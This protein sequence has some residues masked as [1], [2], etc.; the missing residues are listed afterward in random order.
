LAAL[1]AAVAWALAALLIAAPKTGAWTRTGPLSAPGAHL[2]LA[3]IDSRGDALIVWRRPLASGSVVEAAVRKRGR[4]FGKPFAIGTDVGMPLKL[5]YNARGQVL[6]LLGSDAA[7]ACNP[8]VA[9]PRSFSVVS[10]AI[11]GHLGRPVEIARDVGAAAD[12]ALGPAGDAAVVWSTGQ[13]STV[14]ELFLSRRRGAHGSFA[15]REVLGPAWIGQPSAGI[16]ARGRTVVAWATP[17]GSAGRSELRL[18]TAARGQAAAPSRVLA[19]DAVDPGL[20]LG[21]SGAGAVYWS[22]GAALHTLL[23]GPDGRFGRAAT[24]RRA[25]GGHLVAGP[26]GRLVAY[27]SVQ[28][29]QRTPGRPRFHPFAAS[30]DVSHGFGRPLSLAANGWVAAGA[31][32]AGGATYAVGHG[33]ET[34]LED[35]RGRRVRRT[36][37]RGAFPDRALAVAPGG[38]AVVPLLAGS[39]SQGLRVFAALR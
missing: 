33:S 6:L 28:R 13:F 34:L 23:A 35:V 20:T 12:V 11:G 36:V 29:P 26:D 9:C 3:A 10:G 31:A 27:W 7:T 1:G 15:G 37:L 30:G 22:S 4:G 18:A 21:P 25:A 8:L 38:A 2:P 14:G 32:Y 17:A 19:A 24:F 16:D 5:A 39:P